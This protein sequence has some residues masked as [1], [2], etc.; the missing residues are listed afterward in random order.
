MGSEL[1]IRDSFYPASQSRKE[2]KKLERKLSFLAF[3]KA[4]TKTINGIDY[5]KYYDIQFYRLKSFDEFLKLMEQGKIRITFKIGIFRDGKRKGDI[6]D[7]GTG[8]EI[9]DLD[10]QQLFNKIKV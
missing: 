6:H 8:F 10:I 7:R 5:Y 4:W 1:W 3:I 2:R 9:Q